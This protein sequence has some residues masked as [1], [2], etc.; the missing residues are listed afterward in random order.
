M[1]R[2]IGLIVGHDDTFEE[3]L[4]RVLNEAPGVA[5]ERV[6]IGG[7]SERHISRYDVILDR[8]SHW[9]P[10]YRAYLRAAVVAGATVVEDP[11]GPPADE[12][13][14]LSLAARL[15]LRVPRAVLLPQ[16]AYGPQI[17]HDRSLHNLKHPLEWHELLAYVKTPALLRPLD[18]VLSEAAVVSDLGEL[19]RAFDGTGECVHMLQQR[20]RCERQWHVITVGN[21]FCVTL[22]RDPESGAL[23]GP[24]G[25]GDELGRR[26]GEQAL[27][28][29]RLLGRRLNA[30]EMGFGDR[31]L[32]V[33]SAAVPLPRLGPEVVGEGVSAQVVSELAA[34]LI[35]LGRAPRHS[36]DD[37][38]W[39]AG[40][41]ERLQG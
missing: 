19:W 12:L 40:L 35:E 22:E 1:G 21:R 9:V 25:A 23:A 8:F 18:G 39:W 36:R 2:L 10:Q 24:V 16:K 29:S 33:L 31:K 6:E 3:M 4:T 14:A 11:F 20:L 32:A 37:H 27:R 30:V 7:A 38:A 13:F 28:L 15:G 26:A 41:E 5:A 17:H 34:Q